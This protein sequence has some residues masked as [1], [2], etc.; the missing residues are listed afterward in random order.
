MIIGPLMVA[1]STAPAAK[2]TPA[3]LVVPDLSW[4]AARLGL[5]PVPDAWL[6]TAVRAY[7]T[8]DEYLGPMEKARGISFDPDAWTSALLRL[9]PGELY[10]QFLASLNRCTRFKE[11]VLECQRRFLSRL[12]PGL[13]E[14]IEAVLAGGTDGQ[15]RWFL[16]R[17]P[18]LRAMR[19]VLTAEPSQG[20]PDPRI[21]KFLTGMDPETAAAM[22]VHLAGDSLRR[23]QP[24]GERQLGGIGESLAMEVVC[25]QIFNEPHD[26]G[27]MLSRTWALWTRHATTM[28]REKLSKDPLALLEEA[29]TGLKLAELLALGFA[30]WVKTVE[31]RVDGP[32]RINPFI[33]VKLPRETVERFLAL[34]SMTFKEL[35]VELGACEL[36]WQMLPLQTRPLLRLGDEV[37]VLDEPFLW[38][39]VTTGLFWRVSDYVR[40]GE[41]D[42]W[43]PWA[44]AYAEMTEALAEELIQAITPIL[45]DGS[46]AY[47]SEEDIRK[48]FGTK[49]QTP[50]NIDAGID[51]TI[52]V[53]LFEVVNKAMS[54]KARTGVTE[55]FKTDVE[56]AIV[57]KTEQLDGT[58]KLLRRDPQPAGSPL[59]KPATK[60]FPVVVCGNHFPLN[61]VTRNHI[62]ERLR[63]TSVLQDPGT[64]PLAV[65]DLDEL[66]SLASLAK[67]G[68]LLPDLLA[69]W[70]SGPFKKG[71]L[72]TYL[73]SV[74]GGKPLERPPVVKAD[75]KDAYAAITPLLDVRD[76]TLAMSA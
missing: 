24:E 33:L 21:A 9:Y 12:S 7:L 55:A 67:A 35:A 50:P 32:V 2:T 34:F 56:Q 41:P 72:T 47:F 16:A 64:Q 31:N 39:A 53:A 62:E 52:S 36:P 37:V 43:K 20:D 58:A 18:V 68:D 73:S 74:H 14:L 1:T 40:L 71:S 17:Q 19:L 60:V 3:G 22:L 38:E 13:R 28:H 51:F 25:N 6:E 59:A 11:A 70:L 69:D 49:K 45:L 15:P 5:V 29:T 27:G 54:L 75:L 46:S 30:C 8:A 66:E 61:P 4:T 76:D 42:A 23:P 57:E 26:T 44:G 48:A 65:I 10:V 63:G